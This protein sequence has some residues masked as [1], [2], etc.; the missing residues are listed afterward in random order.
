MKNKIEEVA[1]NIVFKLMRTLRNAWSQVW[2]DEFVSCGDALDRSNVRR[3]KMLKLPNFH[4]LVPKAST[5]YP[6][7]LASRIMRNISPGHHPP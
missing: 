3:S 4:L 7:L 2:N 5:S 1:A 6:V